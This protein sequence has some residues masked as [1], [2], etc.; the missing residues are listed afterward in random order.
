M[1]NYRRH[2]ASFKDPSGFVFESNG[3]IR[4]QV[5]RIYQSEYDH[6]MSS[7]LYQKLVDQSLLIP[8]IELEGNLT[9]TDDWYKTIQ[10]DQIDFITYAYEWC[11]EQLKDAALL[12]LQT[13]RISLDYG[14]ILK[15]ATPYNIQF[16]KGKPVFI[17]TLSFEKYDPLHPWVAYRQFCQHFLFPL[18]L[19]FYLKADFQKIMTTYMDGIPVEIVSKML[20]LKSNLSLG[21]WLHVYT[22]NTFRNSTKSKSEEIRFNKKKLLNLISHLE[23]IIKRFVVKKSTTWSNYYEETILGNDYLANKEVLFLD[24][25]KDLRVGTALDL[26]ANEGHFSKFLAARNVKV[27]AT[28]SDS[29]TVGNLYQF[30]REHGVANILPLVLDVSNPSPALGFNSNERSAFHDR[31]KTE[32]VLALALIHHLVIGKNIS[33]ERVAGYFAR[34]SKWLLIEFVP[35]DDPKVEQMMASRKDV[36][37][38]YTEETFEACFEFYFETRKREKIKDTNRILYLMKA[39]VPD[40]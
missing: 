25:I 3:K 27:V 32:L 23:S 6:L 36:F 4:R 14:M 5:N 29:R 13:L 7:G 35:R 38:E 28:D 8:H 1:T 24:F 31:I 33:L 11:F 40:H 2:P 16:Q 37:G 9:Q 21:V 20:P 18:Y 15:D 10:P 19:E 12:T 34:I 30:V 26:G 39:R 17:D 22:Q